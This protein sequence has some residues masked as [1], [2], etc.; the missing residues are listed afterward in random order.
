V[1]FLGGRA[2][3]HQCGHRSG[4]SQSKVPEALAFVSPHPCP[5][6]MGEGTHIE[7]RGQERRRG[8]ASRQVGTRTHT[9]PSPYRERGIEFVRCGA[10]G[11][12]LRRW[13]RLAG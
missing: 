6:S 10:A 11:G 8:T 13:N 9:C 1:V 4:G 12:L 7:G 5:S 3:H 2:T